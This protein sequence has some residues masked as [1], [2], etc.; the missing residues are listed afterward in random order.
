MCH[1]SSSVHVS[2]ESEQSL[3]RAQKLGTF[4]VDCEP[5]GAVI[6]AFLM[7]KLQCTLNMSHLGFGESNPGPH[8]CKARA[9]SIEPS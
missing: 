3:S 8:A 2:G 6:S 1:S 9:L 7:L 5:S 4:P